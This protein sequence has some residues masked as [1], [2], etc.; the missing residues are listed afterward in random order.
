M[1]DHDRFR[2]AHRYAGTQ[3]FVGGFSNFHEADYGRGVVYG[4]FMLP[5]AT[6][7]W[8]DIPRAALIALEPG[9]NQI[10]NVPAVIRAIS[11]WGS[12]NGYD[13][14][15]PTFEQADPGGGVVYGAML[16]RPGVTQWQ[17]VPRAQIGANSPNDVP[18]MMR[19]ANDYAVANGFVAGFPTFEQA[20]HGAG[21]V[22]G[23][24]LFPA[25]TATWRDVHADVLQMQWDYTFDPG[26]TGA[27]IT[28]IMERWGHAYLRLRECGTVSDANK[29]TIIRSFKK[30]INH[31]LAAAA[32]A[33]AS[34][35]LNGSTI[36]INRTNFFG[37]IA[38]EQ[39]QTL[40]HEM[41]HSAGFTHPDRRD[42]PPGIPP[43][44][45]TPGDNGAYYGTVPL[46]AELCIA[47]V[48]SDTVCVPA[49]DG[50]SN[51]R[52]P[53]PRVIGVDYNPPGS[54]VD[55]EHVR[56]TH[57]GPPPIQLQGWTLRD[58]ANHTYTFPTFT[59]PPREVVSVWTGAGADD[60]NN[61]FWGRRKAV[62]NNRGDT[63]TLAD[64]TGAIRNTF[65]YR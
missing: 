49:P 18:N 15:I 65:T 30:R 51:A 52:P 61:L 39:A 58:T 50:M 12:A 43:A 2:N 46:Q 35:P 6:V 20:D 37:L 28:A 63:A 32:N 10:E 57:D 8:R 26:F 14:G 62:W 11:R 40:L 1:A 9:A 53:T 59:L 25:G 7:D 64:P 54:D 29:T 38:R 3:G 33:N 42:C 60:A 19:G 41:C 13:G 45:D 44:C 24:H 31:T 17:D 16:L 4:T 23:I 55:R 27:E 36:N 22:F 56:I 21:V 34:A 48:Q 5:A 47:G